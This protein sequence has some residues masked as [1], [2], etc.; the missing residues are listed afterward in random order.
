MKRELKVLNITTNPNPENSSPENEIKLTNRSGEGVTAITSVRNAQALKT[1]KEYWR[2]LEELAETPEFQQYLHRE[3]PENASEWHDPVGRRKFMKL[4]GASLALAGLSAACTVQ[5]TEKIVPYISL[6]EDLIPGKPLFFATAMS[7]SGV[8]SGLLVESHEG[9]PTKIEGNDIHPHNMGSAGIFEQASVLNLYDPDRSQIVSNVGEILT[10]SAYLGALR[11]IVEAQKAKQGEGLRI[12]TGQIASPTLAQQLKDLQIAFPK[13]KVHTWEPVNNSNAING[14]KMVFGEAVDPVY[15]FD[16]AEVVVSLDA[17]FLFSHPANLKSI[18]DYINTRRLQNGKKAM[19]RFYAVETCPTNTGAKADHRLAVRACEME[20]FTREVATKL[21]VEGVTGGSDSGHGE[22]INAMV[23]DLKER[24][25]KSLVIA[26]KEQPPMVHALAYAIN[27]LLGNIGTTL[28]FVEPIEF[29]TLDHIESIR[30]L[31]NDVNGGK[32]DALIMLGGNPAYDAPADL[33]FVELLKKVNFTAH[34]NLDDN[35]TSGYSRWH[36]SESHYLEAWSDA[37]TVDGTASIVQPLI[38]P[39]YK[40]KSFHEMLAAFTDRPERSSYE[41]VREYWLSRIAGLSKGQAAPVAGQTAT[42]KSAAAQTT[43][44]TAVAAAASTKPATANTSQTPPPPPAPQPATAAQPATGSTVGQPSTTADATPSQAAEQ[45]W[46]KALHDGF[47]AGSAATAKTVTA[48]TGWVSLNPQPL[49][50]KDA[51]E[52]VFRPDASVYDGRFANNGWL[53]ELPKPLTKLTWGNAAHLSP[54]TAKNRGLANGEIITLKLDGR[55]VD[56]PVWIMPG[57]AHNSITVHL[58]YGRTRIGKVGEGVGFNAY[59]IR[60]S[61]AQWFA[62][63]VEYQVTGRSEK[64]ATTQDHWAME[65]R[66][67]VRDATLDEYLKHPEYAKERV[68]NPPADMTL[69]PNYEYPGHKWGMAIDLNNCV[70]CNACVVACQS[71]NNIPVVGKEQVLVGREMHWLRVDRYFKGHQES[72]RDF[73]NDPEFYFQPLPCQH[74]ETAPCEVVCPVAATTHSAEGL[75][76]M[77]YNRCVGTRYCANNCPYKVRRFNFF[78][79]QDFVTESLKMQRNPNVS[80]RSRGVMEKCSYCVQR[81]QEVK[82]EAGKGDRPIVDGEIKTACQQ[83]CPA[84]AII[85]GDLNDPASRVAK[86]QAEPRN[87]SLL[88]ELNTRPRTTYLAEVR[89]PN[90]ELKKA[91]SG[92][93]QH[94]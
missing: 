71:E 88:G 22:F 17:D 80:V 35:E 15:H 60:S 26:G 28:T 51:L 10:W 36:I 55:T 32:V 83:T 84:D 29:N 53:Q 57:H 79:Y 12:L 38:E 69:Y 67:L 48:K 2:S 8:G 41:I 54:E 31:A 24:H 82:I 74:C 3:F 40:S 46:R 93:E 18:R 47:I 58:G 77:V 66:E 90:P 9:R 44:K 34:I 11:P 14:A 50:P 59:I 52:I 4:M 75:N 6:P 30:D 37:R 91:G 68:E 5:P 94:G 1:G 64:M 7:L 70:G 78:L 42:A 62:V 87:F 13:M 21:G 86:L 49:P 81:I 20:A 89:N 27:N 61:N 45:A 43:Q 33:N 16:K 25:G 23:K 72:D 56:A 85:F 19:S 73:V 63:G 92:T 39:L 76:D 65:G